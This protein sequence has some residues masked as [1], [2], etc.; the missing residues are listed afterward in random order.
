MVNILMLGSTGV[1]GFSVAT[2]LR[3]AGHVVH[4][5][6]RDVS[7]SKAQELERQEIITYEGDARDRATW[8]KIALEMDVIIDSTDH[9]LGVDIFKS[10]LEVAQSRRTGAPKITFI[11]TSSLWYSASISL[12]NSNSSSIF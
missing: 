8:F 2:S 4:A 6:V 11:Y 3:R 12:S 10:V 7:T 9:S 1:I 5:I